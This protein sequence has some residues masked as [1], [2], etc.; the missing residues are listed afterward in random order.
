[1]SKF[2]EVLATIAANE[3]G[4]TEIGDT[5]CGPRVNIYKSSTKLDPNE[6]WKWCAAF[7]DWCVMKAMLSLDIKETPT[8]K[9][10]TTA[11][12]WDLINWSLAQDKSTLTIHNPDGNIERG[13]IVIYNFHHCGIV[14]GGASGTSL[15]AVEGN[16]NSAGSRDGGGVWHKRRGLS[17]VKAVIRFRL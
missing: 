16:T 4:V 13:D 12:A 9:R 17:Q 5:N 2:S 8:F 3:V 1:M 14:T 7:V 6:A 11:G 15:F 10:P